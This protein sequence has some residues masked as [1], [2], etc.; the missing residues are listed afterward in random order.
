M[1]SGAELKLS[2]LQAAGLIEGLEGIR[3]SIPLR[4]IRLLGCDLAAAA[5]LRQAAFLSSLS[6]KSD[7]DGW[8]DLPQAG[9]PKATLENERAP[10][11]ERLGSWESTLGIG[12]DAQLAVRK[13]LMRMG[14]LEEKRK[15]I[16]AR[17]HYR[18]LPSAFLAF[19]TSGPSFGNSGNKSLESPKQGAGNPEAGDREI[20]KQHSG[21][22]EANPESFLES[23]ETT[24]GKEG[25]G[26]QFNIDDYIC[27]ALWDAKRSG[28]EIKK[29]SGWKTSLK[30]RIR[31]DGLSV[32]DRQILS[33]W[34]EATARQ[35]ASEHEHEKALNARPKGTEL[36]NEKANAE[37]KRIFEMARAKRA[38]AESQVH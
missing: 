20:P 13:K 33:E 4:L 6:L 30:K 26:G 14:L 10:I 35:Q 11:F 23:S 34:R 17:T 1:T 32:E 25:G 38:A 9:E 18:V 37:G 36:E 7:R 29:L 28:T 3:L 16:P 27:A 15:G 5:F 12:P 2:E 22:P 19:M 8:F 21:N 24:T 31:E